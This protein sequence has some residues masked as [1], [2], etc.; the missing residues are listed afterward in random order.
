[1]FFVLPTLL[2]WALARCSQLCCSHLLLYSAAPVKVFWLP[3]PAFGSCFDCSPCYTI[4]AACSSASSRCSGLCFLLLPGIVFERFVSAV[5][6][7]VHQRGRD[8]RLSEPALKFRAPACIC[9]PSLGDKGSVYS[10][11]PVRVSYISS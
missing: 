9:V 6:R 3:V 7:C 4:V 11:P 2:L 5:L 1:M 8:V 10:A